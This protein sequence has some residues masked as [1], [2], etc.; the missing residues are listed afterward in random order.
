[1]GGSRKTGEHKG[2]DGNAALWAVSSGRAI[3]ACLLAVLLACGVCFFCATVKMPLTL[4]AAV[5]DT[6]TVGLVIDGSPLVTPDPAVLT[7]GRTLVPLRVLMEALGAEVQ[8]APEA[9]TVTITKGAGAYVKLWIDNRLISYGDAAGISYDVCDVAPRIIS[10]RTYVPLRLVAGALGLHVE[11]DSQAGRVLVDTSVAGERSRFFDVTIHG[12]KQEQSISGSMPLSLSYGEGAPQGAAR[13]KYLLLDPATGEGKIVANTWDSGGVT[14][15]APDTA[16]DGPGIL[17][18]VVCDKAGDF[19]AG[20]AVSV[21]MQCEPQVSLM[22]L[23]EGQAMTGELR[24]GVSVNFLASGVEYEFAS[25]QGSDRTRS[26]QVDPHANYTHT[27]PPG[28]SGPIAIRAIAYDSAG[29]P[30]T[31]A[32]I[33][34]QANVPPE[35]TTPRVNLRSFPEDNVGKVPVTLS[36]TRNFDAVSTQ[37]WA[38]NT[39]SGA[40][41]LLEEKPWGDYTWFP[42]PEMAGTW[43]VYVKV[44]APGGREYTSNTRR[45]VVSPAPSLILRGTGPGQVITGEIKLHAL[46]NVALQKVEYVLSNPFNGSQ[47]SLGASADPAEEIAWKPE[48]VNE[49]ERNIQAIGTLANGQI[50]ESEMVKVKV[51]LGQFF[52]A[53]PVTAKDRFVDMVTPMALATQKLNGMSAALQIAQAILETG[54]GQSLPVD[55]YSGLFSNNLFGIKGSGPAGSVLS[56]TQEEYYGVLY[57]TDA[58]FRAYGSVQESWD[59]H[60]DLLLLMERYQPYRNVMYHSVSGAFALKRCGYATDSAYPDKLISIIKQYGLDQLDMQ[61]L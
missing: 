60:N 14:T 36:I 47:R 56:G 17:A 24:F 48:S 27:P 5:G 9:R 3:L 43:D 25:A 12:V 50:I 21:S 61:K 37:Y 41:I 57:R 45:A 32:P 40:S 33:T 51:F 15:F 11:W 58:N 31:S 13:V 46:A 28:Q 18:A 59:D 38:T 52:S 35:D 7:Q 4:H 8:W 6:V 49:G 34:V 22:G 44:A 29:N 10:D 54:W 42:G 30:Y 2:G 20:A 26:G 1:M 16:F 23:S 19:L 39:G 53:K 55:R